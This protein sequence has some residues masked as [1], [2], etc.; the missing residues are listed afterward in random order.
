MKMVALYYLATPAVLL[1]GAAVAIALP[2]GRAAILNPGEH[3]LSEVLYAFT[4]SA[5]SNGSAFGGLSGNTTFYNTLLAVVMLLGRYAPMVFVLGLAGSL[6]RQRPTSA[7]PGAL[8]TTQPAFV[9]LVLGVAVILVF[10]T[11]LPA[12]ALGPLAEGLH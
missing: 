11:F 3:G 2:A 5:N 12:L 1:A 7:D 4:S 6:A 10:L 8:R 9:M